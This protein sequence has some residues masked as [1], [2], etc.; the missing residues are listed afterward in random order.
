MDRG[1]LGVLLICL[2]AST[3]V[4]ALFFGLRAEEKVTLI[5]LEPF[6][7]GVKRIRS[8][9]VELLVRKPMERMTVEFSFLV[10]VDQETDEQLT[11]L[12]EAQGSLEPSKEALTQNPKVEEILDMM[13]PFPNRPEVE[14]FTDT[15]TYDK[16]HS[17]EGR[18]VRRKAD[19]EVG[20]LDLHGF[21]EYLPESAGPG[22]YRSYLEFA[23]LVHD[24]NVSF[25]EGV[26]DY[27]LTRHESVGEVTYGIDGDS[28]LF[29]NPNVMVPRTSD[30]SHVFEAPRFGTVTFDDLEPQQTA[31][32]MFTTRHLAGP[33]ILITRVLVDGEPEKTY[34]SL[35]GWPEQ[36]Y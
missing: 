29:E 20:V 35:F 3:I 4:A 1:L 27:Y 13:E 18:Q 15:V 34:F 21:L 6:E 10:R 2:I 33:S 8:H 11:D 19:Y 23:M 32:I 7:L 17:I 31:S 12:L 14:F 26:S 5:R 28:K 22:V 24:E 25:Y 36:E 30:Y 16:V 9:T